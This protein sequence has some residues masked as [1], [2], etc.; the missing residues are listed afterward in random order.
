MRKTLKFILILMLSLLLVS[1]D[2]ETVF[3][4]SDENKLEETTLYYSSIEGARGLF[5]T[6]IDACFKGG[7]TEYEELIKSSNTFDTGRI[8]NIS[9]SSITQ[10][11]VYR[12]QDGFVG[13]LV[14]RYPNGDYYTITCR[15]KLGEVYAIE[16]Q[17]NGVGA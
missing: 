10:S 16:L 14:F 5:Y 9:T 1:C 3:Q 8:S 17:Y 7:F 13:I 11:G 2:S 4:T 12:V 15:M 6:F